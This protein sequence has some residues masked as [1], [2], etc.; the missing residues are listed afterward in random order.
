[1]FMRTALFKALGG[2]DERFFMYFE[3]ADL[4]RR[5]RKTRARIQSG[6]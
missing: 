4:T 3:D 5:I 6:V 1:M 2:F